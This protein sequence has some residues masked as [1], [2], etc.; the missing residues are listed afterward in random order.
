M[1]QVTFMMDK[2]SFIA[3]FR[4]LK[5]TDSRASPWFHVEKTLWFVIPTQNAH[6]FTEIMS[7]VVRLVTLVMAILVKV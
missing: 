1:L 3:N 2:R 6:L 4:V 7:V 5:E